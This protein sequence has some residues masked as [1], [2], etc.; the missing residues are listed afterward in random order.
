[1]KAGTLWQHNL[2]KCISLSPKIYV[3]INSLGKRTNINLD[4][5]I[6]ITFI[7]SHQIIWLRVVRVKITVEVSDLS[8]PS[9]LKKTE[10][11]FLG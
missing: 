10:V 2:L 3:I 6:I 5:F 11:R 9:G 7:I 4:C 1:V 8:E